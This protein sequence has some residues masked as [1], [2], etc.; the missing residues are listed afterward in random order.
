MEPNQ[1]L[2]CWQRRL[3]PAKLRGVRCV[4]HVIWLSHYHS[5]GRGGRMG[6][7][8]QN[9]PLMHPDSYLD[10]KFCHWGI[11]LQV[12]QKTSAWAT[13]KNG[14]GEGMST[15]SS[16]SN[17]FEGNQFNHLWNINIQR[18]PTPFFILSI[19]SDLGHMAS[20]QCI[21]RQEDLEKEV[22]GL[23]LGSREEETRGGHWAGFLWL[24]GANPL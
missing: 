22:G 12:Y 5:I 14:R 11:T 16:L 23:L 21:M 15:V 13:L 6:G 1:I 7:Y 9:L 4:M 18:V 19:I 10:D 2:V 8:I 3:L 17:Q 24:S 20:P